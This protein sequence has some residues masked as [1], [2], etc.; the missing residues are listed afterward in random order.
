MCSDVRTT[1][2]A[3]YDVIAKKLGTGVTAEQIQAANR[4]KKFVNVCDEIIIPDPQ[5]HVVAPQPE[6][7]KLA[8]QK[9][10]P[11]TPRGSDIKE[12]QEKMQ[13]DV[14]QE[15]E[16]APDG[17]YQRYMD[18][19]EKRMLERM[20]QQIQEHMNQQMQKLN[21]KR[22][23]DRMNQDFMERIGGYRSPAQNNTAP[24]DKQDEI[25]L[26]PTKEPEAPQQKAEP[27]P[28]K[29]PEA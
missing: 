28:T 4:D 10:E 13:K 6:A 14:L 23:M 17:Q 25:N 7:P 27:E 1:T 9:M 18:P 15:K 5:A 3:T 2:L 26:S 29:K 20:N 11:T 8:P 21:M 19:S 24:L 16:A 22:M 12:F